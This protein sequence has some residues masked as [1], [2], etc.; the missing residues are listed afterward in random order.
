MA[1]ANENGEMTNLIANYLVNERFYSLGPKGKGTPQAYKDQFKPILKQ[2]GSVLFEQFER[3]MVFWNVHYIS[4]LGFSDPVLLLVGNFIII[5]T[6]YF[7]TM[8]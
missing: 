6:I 8:S 7:D 2:I 5:Q 3:N 1:N 4:R